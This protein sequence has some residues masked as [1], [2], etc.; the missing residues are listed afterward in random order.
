MEA[1]A[2]SP[3]LL[4]V[5]GNLGTVEPVVGSSE[6]VLAE[7]SGSI[8]EVSGKEKSDL[9]L[10]QEVSSVAT[11]PPRKSWLH[12]AQKRSF[13]KQKF[14]VVEVDGQEKVVVPKEVFVDAKPL[15]EDFLLGNFLSSKAPHV[16]KI[17]M[18]V[19]KIWRLGDKT[20]LIDV[21]E[22]NESTVK[23]RI[24][25]E[26]MRHRILNRRMWNIMGIPMIVSKWTPFTEET[27]PA[28]KSIPLW[29]TLSNIPPTLFTDKGL[30]YLSSAV[31]KPIRLHP[32]TEACAKFDEARILVEAD[33]TKDLP[34]EYILSGTE[35]GELDAVI[36]YT[37]PWLP[38]R[39][40]GCTKWGH[41]KDTCLKEKHTSQ[42]TLPSNQ[43]VVV[44]PKEQEE[45]T[46]STEIQKSADSASASVCVEV[47]N[48]NPEAI[49]IAEK[50]KEQ[51]QGWITPPKTSRTP[52]K[53]KE[54]GLKFAELTILS[55]SYSALSV[56]KRW[57]LELNGATTQLPVML[58]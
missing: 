5:V 40:E 45:G 56:R 6:K 23:F 28:M 9:G 15:W 47:S 21:L 38:P 24:R 42:L 39:C 37:Y 55:N 30:E 18:I 41:L 53:S 51:D 16:G 17:H 22:V 12:A 8:G 50:E 57:K 52:V 31:G 35:E 43:R 36:N 3:T 27:Q 48:L 26:G 10:S 13:T 4:E 7:P 32:E 25:N 29:V 14:E 19:N 33:L 46:I 54:G 44:E 1:P 2:A 20:T 34:R 58:L 11:Q 49:A